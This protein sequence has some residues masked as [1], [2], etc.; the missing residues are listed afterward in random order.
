MGDGEGGRRKAEG[1]RRKAEGG[2]GLLDCWTV[3][4]LDCWTVGLLGSAFSSLIIPPP[5]TLFH[6][7]FDPC[8]SRKNLVTA[9]AASNPD[10][11]ASS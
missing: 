8:E 10:M 11:Q 5:S 2:V 3:G 7:P 6:F 1:G 4:L 9:F